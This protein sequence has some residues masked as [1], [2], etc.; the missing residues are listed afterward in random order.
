M[1]K[2]KKEKRYFYDV[3]MYYEPTT[4][5]KITVILAIIVFFMVA[6]L[7][8]YLYDGDKNYEV[9]TSSYPEEVY[10]YLEAVADEAIKEGAF[11]FTLI[12]EDVKP[13]FTENGNIELH[14]HSLE[15]N[16]LLTTKVTVQ[17]S[18]EYEIESKERN[19]LSDEF[20]SVLKRCRLGTAISF[21]IIIIISV[22]TGMVLF[23]FIA[24]RVSYCNK[25]RDKSKSNKIS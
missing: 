19:I 12:P 22:C 9:Y 16:K 3:M 10:E 20:Q 6:F 23:G 2:N 17:L 11:H 4:I 5:G 7:V 25:K 8:I 24:M 13:K 15:L 21:S 1:E 14:Y 18:E